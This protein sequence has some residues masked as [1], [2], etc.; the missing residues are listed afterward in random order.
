[1][2][3]VTTHPFDDDHLQEECAVFGIFGT[4]EASINTALGLHALQH[5]GQEAAGIVSFDGKT[6]FAH[7]GLGHVG[8]NFGAGSSHIANLVGHVAIGHNRYSTSGNSNALLEIQPFSSELAF[9]GFALAHNGNLTNAARLRSS[10]VETGSLFQSSSDTE[11]IVHL[12]AR[13]HQDT[14][15]DRLIDALKQIEG[16]YSLVCVAK[17]MLI[18]VRDPLGVRPLVLGKQGDAYVLASESCALDIVGAEIVRDLDPGEMVVITK[19]GIKSIKPFPTKQSRFCVF[20]YI[21]FA[22]P[23]SVLEGRGVYHARKAIGAE[24]AKESGA[25]A[26]LVVPVPDSGVPAALGYAEAANIPFELGIIRNHYIGRTFIQPTQQGRNDSVKMKHNANPATVRGKRVVLVDD[27]IVRGTTSRKIVAMMRAAGAA[28]VHMRIA[29]PP[30]K[31]PCFYGVDTPD[32][33]QLIAAKLDIDA[34]AKEIGAD[35][36]AFISID[37][38]YRAMGEAGRNADGPQFCDA[39]F[40]GDYPIKLASGLSGKRVSHGNSR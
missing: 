37:G 6:F 15:T 9:G 3:L 27:S 19:A 10:L 39:C 8:E 1:M 14:V 2:S 4:N 12:V 18:G 5:R 29:S 31:N 24:L 16:A 34:I 35:S 26:D 17:D 40:T 22:R 33:D 32:K 21:Y 11:I 36:L 13:S 23:D 30:T 25:N 28:E 20:E 7:R 38:L